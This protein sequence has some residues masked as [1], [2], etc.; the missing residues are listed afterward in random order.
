MREKSEGTSKK[1]LHRAITLGSQKVLYTWHCSSIYSAE[2]QLGVK[3][4]TY[5]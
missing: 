1:G 2:V 3:L 4:Q 5:P